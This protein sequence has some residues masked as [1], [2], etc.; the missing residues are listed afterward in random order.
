MTPGYT[1]AF[2]Q[3][4]GAVVAASIVTGAAILAAR[5]F[6]PL[7]VRWSNNVARLDFLILLAEQEDG[8]GC[9]VILSTTVPLRV[10]PPDSGRY[11]LSGQTVDNDEECDAIRRVLAPHTVDTR[12]GSFP[13]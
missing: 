2:I 7:F 5:S 8:S 9:S 11:Q 12:E 3:A 1:E 10:G 4:V 13:R 6:E